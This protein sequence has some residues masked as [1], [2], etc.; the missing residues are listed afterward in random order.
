MPLFVVTRW[1][2]AREKITYVFTG[3]DGND[4][5]AANAAAVA[6]NAPN[7][8]VLGNA[9]LFPDDP[10]IKT[11][12]KVRRFIERYYQEH[13][14]VGSEN[15]R[16]TEL[17]SSAAYMLP[18]AWRHKTPLIRDIKGETVQGWKVNP[19]NLTE[20]IMGDGYPIPSQKSAFGDF[21]LYMPTRHDRFNI[22]FENDFPQFLRSDDKAAKAWRSLY[23]LDVTKERIPVESYA[24]VALDSTRLHQLETAYKEKRGA[25]FKTETYVQDW[26][27]R[28]KVRPSGTVIAL[29]G[30][31]AAAADFS[32][33]F[34]KFKAS[35]DF[36][37]VQWVANPT[38]VL[39]KLYK[40]HTFDSKFLFTLSSPSKLPNVSCIVF[41]FQLSNTKSSMHAKLLVDASLNMYANYY[42]SAVGNSRT[43]AIKVRWEDVWEH[44][45]TFMVPRMKKMF[46]I[47]LEEPTDHSLQTFN[48]VEGDVGG[49]LVPQS[50]VNHMSQYPNVLKISRILDASQR[51]LIAK[52][53]R[54]G[55]YSTSSASSSAMSVF[56]YIDMRLNVF[57]DT[58]EE[59]L[60][61]L[62]SLNGMKREDALHAMEAAVNAAATGAADREKV[63][64]VKS[65]RSK[66]FKSQTLLDISINPGHIEYYTR[67]VSSPEQLRDLLFWMQ[68]LFAHSIK[69]MTVANRRA[70]SPPP[71]QPVGADGDSPLIRSESSSLQSSSES[72][73][74]ESE[75]NESSSGGAGADSFNY[76]YSTLAMLQR[77]DPDIFVNTLTKDNV[78]YAKACQGKKQPVV[79]SKAD[80]ERIKK[81]GYLTNLDNVIKYGSRPDNQNYYTCPVI[82]CP[83][84]KVPL[85]PEQY[86]AAGKK[87]PLP[88]EEPDISIDGHVWQDFTTP[89]YIGFHA[90]ETKSGLCMPCC[91]KTPLKAT[92]IQRCG[93]EEVHS[94]NAKK[95]VKVVAAAA[96]A[97]RRTA[98]NE[99]MAVAKAPP[100]AMDV[101]SET[102]LY[103]KSSIGLNRWGILPESLRQLLHS[104]ERQRNECNQPSL[105][106][107]FCFVRK[108]VL[109]A[110]M[111]GDPFM[112]VL[113]VIV[114]NNGRG[115]G[116][117]TKQHLVAEIER[118]LD[119]LTF[120]CLDNGAVLR[121]FG[122]Q[123]GDGVGIIPSEVPAMCR[124]WSR[125]IRERFPEYVQAMGLA[126]LVHGCGGGQMS[127]VM[128]W[129]L[130]RELAIYDAYKRF[131]NHLKSDDSPKHD[132]M[133]HDLMWRCFG[134]HLFV[135]ERVQEEHVHLR[136][137]LSSILPNDFAVQKYAFIVYDGKDKDLYE[138]IEF[139]AKNKQ[140]TFVFDRTTSADLDNILMKM[141][142]SCDTHMEHPRNLQTRIEH[143]QYWCKYLNIAML[144]R[145]HTPDAV[146]LGPGL[147]I[148][149][150]VTGSGMFIDWQLGSVVPVT[151]L[152]ELMEMCDIRKVVYY[153]DLVNSQSE[154]VVMSAVE[155]QIL[156]TCL[157]SAKW[158]WYMEVEVLEDGRRRRR[159]KNVFPAGFLSDEPIVLANAKD[160]TLMTYRRSTEELEK[161]HR[162]Q[163][164]VSKR[165]LKKYDR[166]KSKTKEETE[167]AFKEEDIVRDNRRR[168]K[169]T[170]EEVHP[171]L[172][173]GNREALR[174]WHLGIGVGRYPFLDTEVHTHPRHPNQWVFSQVAVQHRNLPKEM[175]MRV[176]Q[177]PGAYALQRVLKPQAKILQD[178]DDD[179]PSAAAAAMWRTRR[180]AAILG[181]R[182]G[183]DVVM[184]AMMRK[185]T[186]KNRKWQN[187]TVLK[188]RDYNRV[189]LDSMFQW[190]TRDLFGYSFNPAQIRFLQLSLVNRMIIGN[191]RKSL[192]IFLNDPYI[193]H[194]LR[195]SIQ[196]F[197]D[198]RDVDA[199]LEVWSRICNNPTAWPTTIYLH[200]YA[201]LFNINILTVYYSSKNPFVSTTTTEEEAGTALT[202]ASSLYRDVTQS[203]HKSMHRPLVMIQT[204]FK[205]D[206]SE[207]HWIAFKEKNETMTT[208]YFKRVHDA[209]DYVKDLYKDVY[210]FMDHQ[211][212]AV[213]VPRGGGGG[214]SKRPL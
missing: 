194:Q 82:W 143:T 105:T 84:S 26:V 83:L 30:G 184:D 209:P 78:S 161:W 20:E 81:D 120:M 172:A 106:S 7:V 126:D 125:W 79:M 85:S 147:G 34:D 175:F 189:T 57:K 150:Y 44:W 77:M 33:V 88:N 104:N 99:A 166:F 193:T 192:G 22:M 18:Y 68:G 142:R 51:H 121:A 118:R 153:E 144:D 102:Y 35:K 141:R 52:Y 181:K 4:A 89:H 196:E 45:R 135:W 97:P 137:Q 49:V 11:L 182:E 187:M 202:Y 46:D 73:E 112:H 188:L 207:F 115:N 160:S 32:E 168:L 70:P 95:P 61:Q 69:T 2:S 203:L 38:H 133:L 90:K 186:R 159:L 14:D 173:M 127:L 1:I 211:R 171:L 191:H 130:S 170:L 122:R 94:K 6:K 113:A 31:G 178:L 210:E 47:I 71:S 15:E 176:N 108:S 214:R 72:G 56:D 111:M 80:Y 136:C 63:T 169:A 58:Q 201:V 116:A 174:K 17:S 185:F 67:N 180:W 8:R 183:G 155:Y 129:R 206:H 55:E 131:M 156:T 53:L 119:P 123:T 138:P 93:A 145:R 132:M 205:A 28:G 91:K 149:G 124:E 13:P 10:L 212:A 190:L 110:N 40:Q 41:H 165:L 204:Q 5:A 158:S 39:Y 12:T 167:D 199:K 179:T 36:P 92:D 9:A 74:N 27:I 107:T 43:N 87:C 64:V 48:R 42:Y 146:V 163:H 140:G 208:Y 23:L 152:K 128:E 19:T 100:P 109:N 54:G 60:E 148:L 24:S 65:M 162:L 157:S 197:L 16:R 25:A 200:L 198:M 195:S 21:K 62:I 154:P 66:K 177:R 98:K 134:I 114:D 117:A 29:G 139:K 75:S 86:N 3:D 96:S 151:F 37:L 213:A 164:K 76:K 59:V 103:T 101:E 50:I